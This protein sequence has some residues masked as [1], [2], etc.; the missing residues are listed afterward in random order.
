LVL[1]DFI[2]VIY[3]QW[4]FDCHLVVIQLSL[5]IVIKVLLQLITWS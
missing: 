1:V 2:V 3:S 4:S 5:I